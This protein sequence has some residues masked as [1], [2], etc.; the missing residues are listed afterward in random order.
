MAVSP[1]CFADS[2]LIGDAN[3]DGE[4]NSSDLV[5]VYQTG[6][7]ETS[8]AADWSS[9][10]WNCDGRFDSQDVIAAFK[11]GSYSIELPAAK[12]SIPFKGSMNGSESSRAE[13]PFF[14]VNGSAS[15]NATHLGRFTFTYELVGDDSPNQHGAP[16]TTSGT[17]VF[18]A[19]N[20]D[21]IF[22]Q[23]DGLGTLSDDFSFVSVVEM[24]TITGGTGR[25][26]DTSGSFVRK[27]LVSF[28]TETTTGSFE[29]TLVVG[30]PG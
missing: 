18:T 4:F 26:A 2:A 5:Q 25:F 12:A 16:S 27:Y 9:G 14:Y 3:R 17:G 11:Q 19:A 24:H 22:T 8:Q 21:K 10:D 7:Y 29:G 20:G 23:F 15:G 1:T 30:R 28:P 6:T 13:F